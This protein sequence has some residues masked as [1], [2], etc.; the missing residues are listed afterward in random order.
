MPNNYYSH[1]SYP[2]T[3][4]PGRSADLRAELD[5][6]TTGFD[7]LPPLT[8]SAYKIAYANAGATAWATFGG[9]GL[10]KLSTT[11]IPSIAVA[12]TD[13]LTP[14]GVATVTNKV[15]VAGNNTITTAA[16]GSLAATELN[17]AL[18][19]LA[20]DD[21]AIITAYQAA[22]TALTAAI[23]LK[24]PLAS[25]TFTGD[26]QAPTPA[27]SDND[28]SIATT[29]FVRN[30]FGNGFGGGGFGF[31]NKIINGDMRISQ[32]GT[33][34]AALADG[35]YSLDR[36]K[37]GK[38]GA[39]V[40]TASQA[41]DAPTA[42]QAGVRFQNSYQFNLT[43]A[44]TSIAAG[45]YCAI[46]QHIEGYN[47]ASLVQQGFVI[48]FWVKAT[49]AGTYCIFARNSGADRSF[50]QEFTID[51]ADTWEKKTIQVS[52]S[53]SAG[54]WNYTTGI[55]ME[56]GVTLAAG[57]AYQ[58]T[59]GA[60]QTGNFIATANQVN[61]V[62]TGATN[63]LFTGVQVEPGSVAT[64]FES[65]LFGTELALCQ[66][67]YYKTFPYSVAPVQNAGAL[68]VA[69]GVQAA[70]ASSGSTYVISRALPVPMRGAPA[71]VT[72]N[73]SANNSQ[74]RNPNVPADWTATNV[75]SES[76]YESVTVQGTTP[77]GS[78]QGHGA[79]IHFT[80]DAE[81]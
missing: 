56:V 79:S 7:K 58:T 44:D 39:M 65:R 46:R 73:P 47:S 40:H 70:P 18:A 51:A 36:W 53:P 29:A 17:A 35:A 71:I 33:T 66:R 78:S 13:Y 11:G 68:G 22:D 57:S 61:G 64:P 26:P 43:T 25:P 67:Y 12:G 77:A 49:L 9:N 14:A 42:A 74:I 3:G 5:S 4:A 81:L 30:E 72:F 80:A 28:T 31:K 60:W 23:A 62:N 38:S 32:R 2:S 76:N 54:T 20:D 41:T 8:G 24:A 34:F 27:L 15:I 52:A 37:Y 19:E 63:F 45:D 75:A 55:G 16:H 6:I 48:S 1:G 21:A 10:L 50:V 69:T 59:A